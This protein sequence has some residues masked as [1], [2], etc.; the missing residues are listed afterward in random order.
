MANGYSRLYLTQIEGIITAQDWE[1]YLYITFGYRGERDNNTQS[2]SLYPGKVH[3]VFDD[4]RILEENPFVK[5][6]ESG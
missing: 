1:G 3:R 5:Y 2:L 6:I 4:G